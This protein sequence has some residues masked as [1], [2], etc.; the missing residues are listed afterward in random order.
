MK[1]SLQTFGV[2]CLLVSLSALAH[3]APSKLVTDYRMYEDLDD[4][5]RFAEAE[6]FA[7]KALILDE[8]EFGPDGDAAAVPETSLANLAVPDADE[9]LSDETLPLYERVLAIWENAL[10]PDHADIAI[11]LSHLAKLYIAEGRFAE[12]EPMQRR[13]LAVRERSLGPV[14]LQTA[15]SLDDLAALY[16]AQE[17]YDQAEP[18]L[19]RSL[20]IKETN[21][22][23]DHPGVAVSLNNLA[24]LYHVTGRAER[25]QALY[26]RAFEISQRELGPDHPLTEAVRS[27]L[28]ENRT[29]QN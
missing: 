8:V 1:R 22:G 18:L 9:V 5:G 12:A 11:A 7:L 10:G 16:K 25:A 26:R 23:P 27:N 19:K 28:A 13:A 4:L 21:L 24:V 20:A 3:A 14:H 29:E 17:D 6:A 15:K 2:V